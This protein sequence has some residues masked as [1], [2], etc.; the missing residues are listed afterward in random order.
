MFFVGVGTLLC[1]TCDGRYTP[2]SGMVGFHSSASVNGNGDDTET[3][4]LHQ[5]WINWPMLRDFN[6][7]GHLSCVN[8]RFIQNW[9]APILFAD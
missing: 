9:I 8:P 2:G 3:P 7:G 1:G 6:L 5:M 4:P